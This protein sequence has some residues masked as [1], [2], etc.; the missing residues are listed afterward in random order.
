MLHG[1]VDEDRPTVLTALSR[2]VDGEREPTRHKVGV[3]RK[4]GERIDVEI[5]GSATEFEGRPAAMARRF[6]IMYIIW[7]DTM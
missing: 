7:D 2:W 6:G 3:V 5:Y 1:V 4:D